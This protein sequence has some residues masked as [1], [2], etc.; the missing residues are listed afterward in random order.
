V[1]QRKKSDKQGSF[2]RSCFEAHVNQATRRATVHPRNR[3]HPDPKQKKLTVKRFTASGS[4]L[5][6]SS[7][8]AQAP[9]Q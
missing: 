3:I 8:R 9:Q 7:V 5:T 2:H 1:K 6:S 4:L